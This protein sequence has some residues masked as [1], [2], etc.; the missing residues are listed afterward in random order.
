MVKTCP[1]VHRDGTDQGVGGSNPLMHVEKDKTISVL[2]FLF[3]TYAHRVETKC[4]IVYYMHNQ[5]V[6]VY[7]LQPSLF[8]CVYPLITLPQESDV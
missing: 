3:T 2:S 8:G 1:E 7:F 5:S 6:G 4:V